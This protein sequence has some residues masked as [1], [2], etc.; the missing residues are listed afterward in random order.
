MLPR[1][2]TK[3]CLAAKTP[4]DDESVMRNSRKVTA[5]PLLR[6]PPLHWL[7]P[8]A[9]LDPPCVSSAS[10]RWVISH[11]VTIVVV[12]RAAQTTWRGLQSPPPNAALTADQSSLDQIQRQPALHRR[13]NRRI[14]SISQASIAYFPL[15]RCRIAASCMTS[16]QQ[17]VP[18]MLYERC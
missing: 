11:R 1:G 8:P 12:C 5:R 2:Q 6:S 4:V 9:P 16:P 14:N 13:R 3:C 7:L 10:Q 15:Q 17:Q 18:G